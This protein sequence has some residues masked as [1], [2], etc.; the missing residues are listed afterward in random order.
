MIRSGG[1]RPGPV[2]T[3]SSVTAVLL[4]LLLA[5]L[6]TSCASGSLQVSE[7]CVPAVVE[8]R[9]QGTA[10]A[11][12]ELLGRPEEASRIGVYIDVST[13]V[14]G[15][16]PLSGRAGQETSTLRTL[17]QLASEHVLRRYGGGSASIE[18][19][20]VGHRL[21]PTQAPRELTRG[22]FKGES[23]RLELA[24][25]EAFADFRSGRAE[26][27]AVVT[28]LMATDKLVGPLAIAPQIA[29]WLAT[30]DVR[31]GEFH[32]A[33][34]AV[35]ADYWGVTHESGCPERAGL[36]CWYC[37][38]CEAGRRYHRL[39]GIEKLPLYAV[40]AGRGREAVVDVVR[41]IH[42][43]LVGLGIEAQWEL[44]TAASRAVQ[45][46]LS[47]E[48][49]ERGDSG[50]RSQPQWVL[51]EDEG[52]FAC[53]TRAP[54]EFVCRLEN[55]MQLISAAVEAEEAPTDL[56]PEQIWEP[57]PEA[58][59]AAVSGDELEVT[60]DCGVLSGWR[61]SDPNS[62]RQ[63]R[64]DVTARALPE[65]HTSVWDSWSSTLEEM[66]RTV[67]LA[68][69]VDRLRLRPDDYRIVLPLLTVPAGG[70]RFDVDLVDCPV[71]E[72]GADAAESPED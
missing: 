26:V 7:F 51:R 50:E 58:F 21:A 54:A 68:P 27:V 55:G 6:P 72:Q 15:F 13:P 40:L 66:G 36:G 59:S 1:W 12:E 31:S 64:L 20:G 56:A 53:L 34:L 35:Q 49:F 44:L 8:P 69:F 30:E 43:D 62:A 18:W 28:D 4:A 9:W 39:A 37:E 17:A 24:L 29:D 3:V 45:E 33:L 65:E 19:R 22:D 60:V 25:A 63:V 42:A 32:L 38:R 48:V 57:F 41:S 10:V 46:T 71:E 16:L 14:G 52:G 11:Q 23:T 2:T 47:C 70:R 67:Q 5:S 61:A